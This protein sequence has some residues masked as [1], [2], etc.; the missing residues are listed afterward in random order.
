MRGNVI[1]AAAVFGAAMVAAAALIVFGLDRAM[2]RFEAAV[3]RH[4]EAVMNA[5][6]NIRRGTGDGLQDVATAVDAA[7]QRI[8]RPQIEM[9]GPVD[10]R[11]PV[12]IEGTGDGG[13]LPVE[14]TVGT[15][16]KKD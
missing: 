12:K 16:D 11:Q 9:R 15:P 4:G 8:A 2:D 13:S 6:I 14:A 1:L 5:G 3:T 7:G 10:V